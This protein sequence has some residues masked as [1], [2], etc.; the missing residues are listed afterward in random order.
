[1][2]QFK[3]INTVTQSQ[4]LKKSDVGLWGHDW[5]INLSFLVDFWW[6]AFHHVKPLRL[7]LL[8]IFVNMDDNIIEH[9][10][11]QSA[12]LIEMSEVVASQ[13][14]VTLVEVWKHVDPLPLHWRMNHSHQFTSS[15]QSTARPAVNCPHRHETWTEPLSP[16]FQRKLIRVNTT[17]PSSYVLFSWI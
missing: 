15:W 17:Q 14:Q 16:R 4:P 6:S 3:E 9:Y 7:C 11:N 12:F 1:M 13:F 10:T 2:S 5:K 8:R